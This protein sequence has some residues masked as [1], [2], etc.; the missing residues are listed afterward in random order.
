MKVR[1]T[2]RESISVTLEPNI[3]Y[4]SVKNTFKIRFINLFLLPFFL[5]FSCLA[6]LLLF[7]YLSIYTSLYHCE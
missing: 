7:T 4:F 3:Y 6:L 5:Q 2:M 1:H